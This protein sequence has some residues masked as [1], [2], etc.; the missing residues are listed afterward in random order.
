MDGRL[1]RQW[2]TGTAV[3]PLTPQPDNWDEFWET[4]KTF[5]NSV[6]LVGGNDKGSFRLSLGR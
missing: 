4:G 1:V 5:T 2:W 6:A 3:A